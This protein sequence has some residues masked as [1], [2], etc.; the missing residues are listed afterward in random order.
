MKRNYERTDEVISII[1]DKRPY[2]NSMNQLFHSV[3]VVQR[4]RVSSTGYEEL[5]NTGFDILQSASL[6]EDIV[7]LFEFTYSQTDKIL[8]E[9]QLYD[10][11]FT[12][13]IIDNFLEVE[14]DLLK[15]V[16]YNQIINSHFY[17][18]SL[19]HIRSIRYW[20]ILLLEKAKEENSRTLRLIKD[21]LGEED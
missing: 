16:T 1:E 12:K 4:L 15:P 17:Y 3:R 10:D 18:S 20:R 8:N 6:K 11:H 13:F 2:E 21:E 14:H 19:L 7:N 5:K 9:V